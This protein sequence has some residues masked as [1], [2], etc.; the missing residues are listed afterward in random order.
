MFQQLLPVHENQAVDAA[1]RYKP[2]SKNGLAEGRC[3]SQDPNIVSHHSARRQLLFGPQ[4]TM[5]T[6]IEWG[7]AKSFIA[8]RRLDPQRGKQILCLRQAPS[9]QGQVFQS[10]LRAMDHTRFAE[11]GQPHCLRPIELRVL[12]R[13][14]SHKAVA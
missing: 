13:S 14:Q 12:E 8:Q 2:G 9:G 7:A 4:L 5:E 10:I 1:M 6:H 11:Y 3:S